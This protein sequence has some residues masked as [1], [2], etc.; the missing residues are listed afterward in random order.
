M[1]KYYLKLIFI[2]VYILKSFIDLLFKE[3]TINIITA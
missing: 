1:I 3:K 2:V